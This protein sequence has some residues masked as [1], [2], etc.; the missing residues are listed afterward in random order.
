MTWMATFQ[1]LTPYCTLHHL[2]EPGHQ[3][4]T[5]PVGQHLFG[6]LGIT[7]HS[8]PRLADGFIPCHG[9]IYITPRDMAK[10]GALY[11][12]GGE[13]QGRRIVSED[14]VR[15]SVAPTVSIAGWHLSWADQYGY[16]WWL[17]DYH[18]AARTYPSLKALG[19]GGQEIM[20]FPQQD[21]IVV[22]TGA[23]YTETPPTDDMV[24]RFILPAPGG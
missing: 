21:M 8:F 9:D 19:W 23:N 3:P 11:L 20:V 2:A 16:L 22:F 7:S 1:P 10:L 13:W 15:R 5:A 24:T 14:W 12:N 4:T 6:P 17:K 18:V